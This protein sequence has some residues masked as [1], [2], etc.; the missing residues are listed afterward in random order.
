MF[1]KKSIVFFDKNW[2]DFW[3]M[4]DFRSV[5]AWLPLE[6]RSTM[7]EI[8]QKI[9]LEKWFMLARFCS[10]SKAL[11][12]FSARARLGSKIISCDIARARLG[13]KIFSLGSLELEK[14]TLVPNTKY[15][16]YQIVFPR[17]LAFSD[18]FWHFSIIFRIN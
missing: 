15:F 17:F 14:F 13:S 10:R 3:F 4:L 16:S 7:L 9:M 1:S 18:H 12:A 5:F 11:E 8:E 2:T 6:F